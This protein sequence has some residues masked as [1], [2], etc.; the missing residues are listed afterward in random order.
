MNQ[1]NLKLPGHDLTDG[2]DANDQHVDQ[3]EYNP[4][5]A[6]TQGR[7][8]RPRV[9]SKQTRSKSKPDS[10]EEQVDLVTKHTNEEKEE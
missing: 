4:A 10:T 6:R 5:Q 9:R 7:A 3:E 2:T 1:R 8:Q